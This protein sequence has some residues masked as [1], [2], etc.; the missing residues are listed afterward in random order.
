MLLVVRGAPL[1]EADLS[2]SISVE[3]LQNLVVIDHGP[4]VPQIDSEIIEGDLLRAICNCVERHGAARRPLHLQW[5]CGR[6]VDV[7]GDGGGR[8]GRGWRLGRQLGTGFDRLDA[9]PPE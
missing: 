5:R 7:G 3:G 9:A 6:R 2:I 4:R 8:R 1:P